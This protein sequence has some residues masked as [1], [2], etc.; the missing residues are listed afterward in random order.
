MPLRAVRF[1]AN[2]PYFY[3]LKDAGSETLV[4]WNWNGVFGEEGVTADINFSHFTEIGPQRIRVGLAATAPVLV[5]H[6]GAG[7]PAPALAVR[8]VQS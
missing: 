2:D 7:V 1:L 3:R 5:T 6:G 4:N 8:T